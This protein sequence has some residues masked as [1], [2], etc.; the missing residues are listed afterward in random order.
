MLGVDRQLRPFPQ[1]AIEKGN[2]PIAERQVQLGQVEVGAEIV[3]AWH[4]RLPKKLTTRLGLIPKRDQR[5]D[6]L[7]AGQLAKLRLR[8]IFPLEQRRCLASLKQR[9]RMIAAMTGHGRQAQVRMAAHRF[10]APRW[11]QAAQEQQL[12]LIKSTD[13][14]EL[15]GLLEPARDQKPMT[16]R[17]RPDQAERQHQRIA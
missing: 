11:T 16:P 15:R 2:L 4:A 6:F 10:A 9:H 7:V 3:A 1:R 14:N 12:G 5:A 13:M 8:G 17:R